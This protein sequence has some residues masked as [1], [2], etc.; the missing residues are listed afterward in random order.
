ML[1]ANNV[2]LCGNVVA[3]PEDRTATAQHTFAV[4]RMAV[5]N[6][7]KKDGEIVELEPFFVDVQTNGT[8]ARHCLASLCKGAP[9]MIHGRLLTD[10]W[11]DTRGETP[12]TRTQTKIKAYHVGLD[13]TR[14]VIDK[15]YTPKGQTLQQLALCGVAT[16]GL[17]LGAS[18]GGSTSAADST[19]A[20][21]DRYQAQRD[22]AGVAGT[23]FGDP[24]EIG[25]PA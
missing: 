22:A 20:A 9:V 14:A 5:T 13:L 6:S 23:G 7:F 4:F 19:R 25:F 18:H 11:T 16:L 21:A 24:A 10:T 12:V 2:Q 8:L 17:G 1:N 3:D 15:A